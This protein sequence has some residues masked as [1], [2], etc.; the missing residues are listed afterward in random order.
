MRSG[1]PSA[2][3]FILIHS[4]SLPSLVFASLSEFGQTKTILGRLWKPQVILLAIMCVTLLPPLVMPS[5]AQVTRRAIFRKTISAAS[6]DTLY[7]YPSQGFR[8]P[9]YD[10]TKVGQPKAFEIPVEVNHFGYD[11]LCI[12]RVGGSTVADLN[13]KVKKLVSSGIVHTGDSLVVTPSGDV[14]DVLGRHKCAA[15]GEVFSQLL[16]YAVIIING[17]ASAIRLE[18][19]YLNNFRREVGK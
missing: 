6:T 3:S 18:F 1:A 8:A 11:E 7:L 13:I 2:H 10:T 4:F 17:D 5:Y 16:G 12:R 15:F 9:T 14:F 19:E